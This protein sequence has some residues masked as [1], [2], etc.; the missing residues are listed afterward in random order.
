MGRNGGISKSAHP[1][2]SS[3]IPS[4]PDR[5]SAT[6]WDSA[7]ASDIR[8]TEARANEKAYSTNMSARRTE[9]LDKKY[10]AASCPDVVL[11]SPVG[12]VTSASQSATPKRVAVLLPR[13]SPSPAAASRA[14]RSGGPRKAATHDGG[15]DV[16]SVRQDTAHVPSPRGVDR[17]SIP[18]SGQLTGISAIQSEGLVCTPDAGHPTSVP[19]GGDATTPVAAN[20]KVTAAPVEVKREVEAAAGGGEMRRLSGQ[21]DYSERVLAGLTRRGPKDRISDIIFIC[22]SV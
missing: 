10:N 20:G 3:N 7:A 6:T 17:A 1:L 16:T 13:L 8:T 22:R 2:R 19:P 5:G 11:S 9:A 21:Q 15:G 4:T 18:P 14:L 12:G